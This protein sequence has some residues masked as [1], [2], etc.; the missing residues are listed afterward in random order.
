M[1]K[2]IKFLLIFAFLSYSLINPNISFSESGY[3]RFL[4]SR[5]GPFSSANYA[6]NSVS[7]DYLEEILPGTVVNSSMGSS[8][9]PDG[10]VMSPGNNDSYLELIFMLPEEYDFSN[11]TF[12][13]NT[14][15]K[16]TTL[17]Q[18]KLIVEVMNN[19]ETFWFNHQY[20]YYDF[21]V[22][23]NQTINSSN[24]DRISDAI[25]TSDNYYPSQLFNSGYI[26][27]WYEEGR[28]CI[29]IRLKVLA[30]H[31]VD[32]EFVDLS[33]DNAELRIDHAVDNDSLTFNTG[34]NA[35]WFGQKEVFYFDGD[36]AR[37]GTIENGE[38][39]GLY[40]NISGPGTLS[41]Y[42]RVSSEEFHDA[43]YFYFDDEA[44]PRG[45]ISGE[46]DWE[47][48]VL[49]VP[50]GEH[51][52]A[53]EYKKDSSA[54]SGDDCGWLDSI[55]FCNYTINPEIISMPF[56]GG[57]QSVDITPNIS[58][59]SWTASTGDVSWV[60]VDTTSG[61]GP[62]YVNVL[63]DYN[64]GDSRTG[65][66]T[67]AGH[68]FTIN[69]GQQSCFNGI[70][71]SDYNFPSS[72][73]DLYVDVEI[74]TEAG[75]NWT[76]SADNL[77]WASVVPE[78][79]TGSAIVR[80]TVAPNPG[81]AR[82]GNITIAGQLFSLTQDRGCNFS[83]LP[84]SSEFPYYGG[85]YSVTVMTS[86]PDCTWTASSDNLSWVTISP[87]IGTGNG[88]VTIMVLPNYDSTRNADITIAEN[89]FTI[90]QAYNPSPGIQ[91][92]AFQTGGSLL[93]TSA[94]IGIDGTIY[95]NGSANNSLEAINPDG[96]SKWIFQKSSLY[97]SSS[98]SIGVD[99]TIYICFEEF[100]SQIVILSA[101]NADG[102]EEWA[103]SIQGI[104]S[105]NAPPTID[106]DGTIYI[107]VTNNGYSSYTLYAINP[108]GTQ[109]WELSFPI[110]L[111]PP[112]IACDG[113]IYLG[114]SD[115]NDSFL[116]ALNPDGT[117]KWGFPIAANSS[118]LT[119]IGTDGTI[120]IGAFWNKLLAVNSD[121]T[122]KWNFTEGD[123]MGAESSPVI[124]SDGTIYIVDL[125]GHLFAVNPD[126]T[127]RWSQ[128]FQTQGQWCNSTPAIGADGTIYLV[129]YYWQ[130][131]SSLPDYSKLYAIN[132][133]GSQKWERQIEPSF[134][135]PAIGTDGTI[136]VGAEDGN[137]HA[138]VSESGGLAD[139]PWPMFFHDTTH[140]GYQPECKIL[141]DVD[142]DLSIDLSDAILSLRLIAGIYSDT[143]INKNGD[144]NGDKKIGL[145]EVV[146]VMQTVA[147][148]R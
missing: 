135:S 122:Q 10:G 49:D 130:E 93:S 45:I 47:Q 98:P 26:G 11:A 53:W 55:M 74:T 67:I 15:G 123:S 145:P 118:F 146:F 148:V 35:R 14:K 94:A 37:S 91:K 114:T 89:T 75:C 97:A 63:V 105:T 131:G 43:L 80:V 30:L 71:P 120:Y 6:V 50:S 127:K 1:N 36:A 46:V 68:P 62:S 87:T 48:F 61:T 21:Y 76:T 17:Y 52:L 2:P 82:S 18:D 102:T 29:Y 92:W 41:F 144:V 56:Y 136:Y 58:E 64:Y 79:G 12:T 72:G 59:C 125:V 100:T 73:D 109:K 116:L 99:N 139:S 112:T 78:S 40:T 60:Q 107:T 132:P 20:P 142:G 32:L 19:S 147:G 85:S 39:S 4:C 44:N 113:T 34:P 126:G 121:G 88:I 23:E 25:V 95:V 66:I 70:I 124:A 128:S 90:T 51:Q 7:G 133:D 138:I 119:S 108:D 13:I 65:I 5:E 134:S 84:N 24:F 57:V 54:S 129:N 33:W 101:V 69:Q 8:D 28:P 81:E 106:S 22:L 141:G 140:T 103:F 110:I 117:Q 9:Y 3:I 143:P 77:A 83:I 38:T 86:A 16:G 96:T 31:E 104:S 111:S 42:W 137:L 115:G 27:E